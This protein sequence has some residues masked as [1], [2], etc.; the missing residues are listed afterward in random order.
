[1]NR[2]AGKVAIVTGGASRLGAADARLL[3]AE[4][5]KVVITDVQRELAE[6]VAAS[7]PGALFLPHD[8]R[9]GTHIVIDNGETAR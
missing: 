6:A 4:G 3:A 2:V 9:D 5:A 8:V 1:M 7:I